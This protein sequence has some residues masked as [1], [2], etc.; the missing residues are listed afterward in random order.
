V[1]QSPLGCSPPPSSIAAPSTHHTGRQRL[2]DDLRKIY[3][4]LKAPRFDL[5]RPTAHPTQ[6]TSQVTSSDT[7]RDTLSVPVTSQV[8][9][10]VEAGAPVHAAHRNLAPGC[11]PLLVAAALVTPPPPRP[12]SQAALAR[13]RRCVAAAAWTRAAC[14]PA[15]IAPGHGLRSR[16]ASHDPPALQGARHLP[17][18][19]SVCCAHH[20]PALR[21]GE[22]STAAWQARQVT[23][24]RVAGEAAARETHGRRDT[25]SAHAAPPLVG[26][27]EGAAQGRLKARLKSGSRRG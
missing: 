3:L 8:T 18:W 26:A 10:L 6:I 2:H 21:G 27:G 4:H 20:P 11:T 16:P 19:C 23:R 1:P 12:S 25:C 17:A 7:L 14:L 9:A 5:H 24:R 15:D 22:I 13:Q